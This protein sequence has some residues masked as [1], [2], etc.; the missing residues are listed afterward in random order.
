MTR[1]GEP[2]QGAWWA[3]HGGVQ[4]L[5]QF[6]GG[7]VVSTGLFVLWLTVGLH[8]GFGS[9]VKFVFATS[10]VV[11]AGLLSLVN[12]GL[13]VL[14]PFFRR[15]QPAAAIDSTGIWFYQAGSYTV[16]PWADIA[17]VGVSYRKGRFLARKLLRWESRGPFALEVYPLAAATEP[18]DAGSPAASPAFLRW[19][20][21]EQP[22]RPHL[23]RLRYRFHLLPVPGRR[24]V[25]ESV[26]GY[27]PAV[28]LGEY[29]RTFR[30]SGR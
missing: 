20:V 14:F 16:W 1:T 17:A 11:A 26:E 28:W 9:G 24:R 12:I 21:E 29:Q 2:E 4:H 10:A 8:G 15:E 27:A 23:P 25:R 5:L 19:Q 30:L 13:L 22:P 6:L 18:G 7:T 3:R